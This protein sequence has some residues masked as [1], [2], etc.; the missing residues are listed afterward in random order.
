MGLCISVPMGPVGVLC[1]RRTINHGRRVGILTGVGATLGDLFYGI[2]TFLVIKLGIEGI[3]SWLHTNEF[4]IQNISVGIILLLG[5][6]TLRSSYKPVDEEAKTIAIHSSWKVLVTSFAMALMN[7][8]IILGFILFFVQFYVK[9]RSINPWILFS[10]SMSSIVLGAFLRWFTITEIVLRI[11]RAFTEGSI[12][13]F[14]RIVGIIFIIIA[15]I[16][17][18]YI[19]IQHFTA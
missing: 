6:L 4:I 1:V 9:D 15:I 16:L 13:D 2:I 12:H 18:I 10:I 11:K 3:E 8:L 19:C 17:E 5:L 7:P 14:N